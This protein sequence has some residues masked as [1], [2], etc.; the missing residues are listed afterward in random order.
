MVT[1]GRLGHAQGQ[2]LEQALRPPYF[3]RHANVTRQMLYRDLSGDRQTNI[4][5]LCYCIASLLPYNCV[6]FG[7]TFKQVSYTMTHNIQ[8]QTHETRQS[9]ENIDPMVIVQISLT[10]RVGTL[11]HRRARPTSLYAVFTIV[12]NYYLI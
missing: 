8:Q 5:T 3:F 7:S 10:M 6:L 12:F 4:A 1:S 2:R 9:K 11:F